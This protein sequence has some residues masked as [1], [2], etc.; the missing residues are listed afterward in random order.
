MSKVE[1]GDSSEECEEYVVEKILSRRLRKGKVE[2]YLKWKGYDQESDNTWEPEENLDCK[3]LIKEFEENRLKDESAKGGRSKSDNLKPTTSRRRDSVRSETDKESASKTSKKPTEEKSDKKKSASTTKSSD[4][5]KETDNVEQS[6]SKP[7]AERPK[8]SK[9]K[10]KVSDA[11]PTDS[12]DKPKEPAG[13]KMDTTE[14][15]ETVVEAKKPRKDKD[16][17]KGPKSSLRAST[18]S[19]SKEPTEFVA[20][21][22]P[23]PDKPNGFDK[24]FKVE[25][26]LGATDAAGTL[27]FI[28]QFKGHDQAEMIPASVVNEKIPQTVIKFYESKLLWYS[29]NEE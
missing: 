5:K 20:D 2:Y 7:D 22:L 17:K 18:D 25:R 6:K 28:L 11:V 10:A 16:D 23:N 1:S 15:E 26:I 3:D 27:Y 9:S 4:D 12:I 24:G 19:S 14:A 29:D 21:S 13:E 8:S